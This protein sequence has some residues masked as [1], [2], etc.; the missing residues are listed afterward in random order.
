MAE[1]LCTRCGRLNAAHARFCSICGA[2]DFQEFAEAPVE[3]L[4]GASPG[5][6]AVADAAVRI[7]MTRI[8]V[9]SA[10]TSSGLYFYY[11]LYLTWKQLQGETKGVHYPVWHALT[12]L[13]PIYGLFRLHRHVGVVQALALGAG[14]TTSLTPGLAVVL[15]A[16]TWVLGIVSMGAVGLLLLVLNLISFALTTTTMLW[17]QGALNAYWYKVR[18]ASLQDAPIG[19]GEKTVILLGVL[20]WLIVFL[21]LFWD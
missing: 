19:V 7:S 18:G 9:L 8:V 5:Q 2:Q 14:V 15:V 6:G 12:M 1:K 3:Q 20:L 16:L 11:W 10:V 13:I 21:S 17:V 4:T